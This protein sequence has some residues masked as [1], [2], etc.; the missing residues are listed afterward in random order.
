MIKH[1]S[2]RAKLAEIIEAGVDDGQVPS[3]T[4]QRAGIDS[5]PVFPT[6]IVGQPSWQAAP[7]ERTYALGQSTFPIGC[8]VNRSGIGGDAP[9]IDALEDLWPAVVDLLRTTSE[10][11]QTLGGVCSQALISRADFGAFSIQG[12]TYPAQLITIELYG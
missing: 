9:S 6:V 1:G 2:A 11:D 4:V 7:P 5:L 10:Q 8:V 3:A 12:Q